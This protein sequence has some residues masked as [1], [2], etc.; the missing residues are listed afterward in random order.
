MGGT[1]SH[2]SPIAARMWTGDTNPR[3]LHGLSQD[4]DD[5]ALFGIPLE[6]LTDAQLVAECQRYNITVIVA[7]VGDFHTRV[8][9]DASPRFQSYY[10]NGYFFVYRVKEYENAWTDAQNAA[11]DLL[12][13]ADD[14]ITLHVRAAYADA[15]VTVKVYAY[16]LW[17]A[18]TDAGAPLAFTHDDLAL[19]R[20]A[21]P[22]GKNYTVTLRYEDSSAEQVGFLISTLS[23]TFL[24]GSAMLGFWR[25]RTS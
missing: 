9:L 13:F 14:E 1:Y 10:N 22:P 23:G 19:M 12:S 16:P 20:I 2:W 24:L 3:V 15:S 18:Y 7:S 25:R 17:H 6:K 8:F 21:L 5:H 4:T 11:V